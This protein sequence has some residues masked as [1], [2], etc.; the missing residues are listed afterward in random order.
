MIFSP[1]RHMC[2]CGKSFRQTRL[3]QRIPPFTKIIEVLR[4]LRLEIILLVRILCEIEKKL[5]SLGSFQILPV[6]LTQG[7]PLTALKFGMGTG[8][9]KEFT[10]RKTLLDSAQDSGDVFSIK[11][12]S[13]HIHLGQS[14]KS[15]KRSKA[16]KTALLL[17]PALIIPGQR[18]RHGTRIPPSKS[19]AFSPRNG[20]LLPPNS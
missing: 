2:L 18:I 1:Q 7:C 9:P 12:M 6:T 10:R 17:L 14:A 11:L 15:G 5:L 13:S 19:V 16:L 8:V 4:M 3:Q 20:L